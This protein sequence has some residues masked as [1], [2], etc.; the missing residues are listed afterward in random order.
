MFGIN[1][2]VNARGIAFWL[3]VT[4]VSNGWVSCKFGSIGGY[5]GKFR[6]S[7]LTAYEG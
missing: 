1:Q 7:E 2:K 5:A 3:T 4:D 6:E